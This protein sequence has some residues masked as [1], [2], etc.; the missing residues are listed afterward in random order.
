MKRVISVILAAMMA[1]SVTACGGSGSSGSSTETSAKKEVAIES[2]SGNKD[3]SLNSGSSTAAAE[4]A[5][6]AE[7][8]VDPSR[9]KKK[10]VVGT[11][12]EPDCFAPWDP[13]NFATN[14]DNP[15]VM[16]IYE[17]T[18]EL[19][20]DGTV[21]NLLLD[22]YEVNEDYTEWTMHYKDNVYF[23]NGDH[24]TSAD[25]AWSITCMANTKIGKTLWPKFVEAREDDEYTVTVVLEEPYIP[26]ILSGFTGCRG[27]IADKTYFESLGSDIDAYNA[28]PVG[29]GPYM[30][31]EYKLKESETMVKNPNYWD[32]NVDVFF[33]EIQL[34]FLTDQNTQMLA[35]ENNEIDALLAAKIPPLLM[36][37]DNSDIDFT[38]SQYAGTFWV[39]F[40]ETGNVPTKDINIR[41]G[42]AAA[43][44]REAINTVVYEGYSTVA[45]MQCCEFF[46]GAPNMEDIKVQLPQYDPEA[47]KKYFEAAGYN[48][49]EI[50]ILC[51]SGSLMEQA[52][53]VIQG[54]LMN[55]GVN[56]TV[57]ALD[58]ASVN[59]AAKLSEG[60]CIRIQ[61]A[62]SSA[63]DMSWGATYMSYDRS[64]E[65][66]MGTDSHI[67]F[68]RV[69]EAEDLYAKALVEFD[70]E[71]RGKMYARIEE[72]LNEEVRRVPL[73]NQIGT[74]A[75]HNWIEGVE[76]RPIEYMVFFKY[77]H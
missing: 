67:P 27:V 68:P 46:T 41:K 48:G 23:S 77:W 58:N 17:T 69:E 71:A 30:F 26:L 55:L 2:V 76:G 31:K 22:S 54:E 57:K 9:K 6:T 43:I 44:D 65:M 1:V 51:I 73:V 16:Q 19:Q 64:V 45:D 7:S 49:E 61:S 28:A 56:A 15:M 70:Q 25:V 20:K 38:V 11:D 5:T 47:A 3:T 53:V 33:E 35:L 40:N 12:K 39:Q 4:S 36:L 24:M 13:D 50:T 62:T 29:T 14:S 8:T 52:A 72:I 75:Y 60:Y 59:A 66:G 34:K 63:M 10:L 18:F 37:P 42:I 74:I 21:K 32:K